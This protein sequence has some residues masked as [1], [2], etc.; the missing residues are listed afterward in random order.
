M[1]LQQAKTWGYKINGSFNGILG[2]MVRGIVDV[3]IAPFQYKE[4]RMDVCEF[5]VE[6]WTVRLVSYLLD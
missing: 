1:N 3:S 2:D 6:T 4:E 5:T